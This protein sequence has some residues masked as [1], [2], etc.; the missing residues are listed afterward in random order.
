MS[1]SW[2]T[3]ERVKSKHNA[4]NANSWNKVKFSLEAHTEPGDSIWLHSSTKKIELYTK[5]G[6][7]PKWESGEVTWHELAGGR[8]QKLSYKYIHVMKDGSELIEQQPR[9][10]E[11]TEVPLCG[12]QYDGRFRAPPAP[13]PSNYSSSIPFNQFVLAE[14]YAETIQDI[15][16]QL[17]DMKQDVRDFRQLRKDM[18]ALRQEFSDFRESETYKMVRLEEQVNQASICQSA[19]QQQITS[20]E[21]DFRDLRRKLHD[22]HERVEHVAATQGSSAEVQQNDNVS[23]KL[24]AGASANDPSARCQIHDVSMAE[25]RDKCPEEQLESLVSTCA[26]EGAQKEI[27]RKENN[28]RDT[29]LDQSSMSPLGFSA[30]LYPADAISIAKEVEQEVADALKRNATAEEKR[31][32][33]KKMLLKVHPDKGGTNKAVEWL[34]LWEEKHL[35]WFLGDGYLDRQAQT[36][37]AE[38]IHYSGS[39]AL[40]VNM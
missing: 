3:Q 31:L 21:R 20:I 12:V 25:P 40:R 38:D 1:S 16:T 7:Y 6:Q 13:P 33:W 28:P 15:R 8:S 30:P 2:N 11:Y 19:Q 39:D 9:I 24:L 22:L 36:S 10:L 29:S 17:N 32:L 14:H 37:T 18:K 34:K 4:T 5:T 26:E 35:P 23:K 27:E